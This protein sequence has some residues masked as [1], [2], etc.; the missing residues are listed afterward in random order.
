[1]SDRVKS[2]ELR[3]EFFGR[4]VRVRSGYAELLRRVGAIFSPFTVPSGSKRALASY[5]VTGKGPFRLLRGGK[6]QYDSERLH[7]IV[8]YLESDLLSLL[9]QN[10]DS[11]LLIH[12]GA[13]A[14]GDRGLLLPARAGSGKTTLTASLI[15]SGFSYATDEM[16]VIGTADSLLQPFPK[17]LNL[18]TPSLQLLEP[19]GSDLEPVAPDDP[20]D[21]DRVHHLVVGRSGRLEPGCSCR[22][23]RIVF[24][25]YVAGEPDRLEPVPRA[26]A[27]GEIAQL[28]FNYYRLKDGALDCLEG[29]VGGADCYR[30][31]YSNLEAAIGILQ[32]LSSDQP[33]RTATGA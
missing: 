10:L 6:A 22:I 15:R 19:F 2:G 26:R 20:V 8:E 17:A 24:P 11:H 13:V 12:A 33:L 7:Y 1:M 25:R 30:L 31:T 29:L 5:Q 21:D 32:D 4:P 27:I 16:A 9:I 18:K 28:A 14:A 3:F 23:N